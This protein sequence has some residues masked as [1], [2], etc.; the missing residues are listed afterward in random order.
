MESTTGRLPSVSVLKHGG[1]VVLAGIRPPRRLETLLE[2][3]PET[4]Q[5]VLELLDEQD[6]AVLAGNVRLLRDSFGVE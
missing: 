4:L 1:C 3:D 2:S 6:P 5:A